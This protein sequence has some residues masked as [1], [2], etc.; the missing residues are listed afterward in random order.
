MVFL[1]FSLNI[2]KIM[3]Y[4]EFVVSALMYEIGVVSRVAE[5]CIFGLNLVVSYACSSLAR[6]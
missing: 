3:G 4:R 2:G 5:F 1:K 6:I